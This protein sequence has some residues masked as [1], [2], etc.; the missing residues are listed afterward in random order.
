MEKVRNLNNSTG[1]N[2]HTGRNFPKILITVYVMKI[3][4]R[5]GFYLK[6]VP[7]TMILD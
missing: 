2:K 3:N 6:S 4:K 1:G 5:T 7:A